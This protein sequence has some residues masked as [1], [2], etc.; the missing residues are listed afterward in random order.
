MGE[1]CDPDVVYFELQVLPILQSNCAMSG[2]HD[3][4]TAQDGVILTSYQRVMQTADVRPYNL[5]GSDLYEVITDNDPDDRMPPPPN[6]RLSQE[7]ISLIGQWIM[8]GAENKTCDPNAGE[9][10]TQNV[11]FSAEI[12][13]VIQNSCTGCHSGGNPS[14]GISLTNHATVSAAAN[15]GKLQGVISWQDG[16]PRMPQGGQKLN[17]CFI[18]KVAAWINAGKPN[19]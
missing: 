2:C 13:P 6:S 1:P 7:Q 3:E 4:A 5:S 11:S 18:D 17:Q 14:G 12:W 15:N 8:Q 9:C 19:N 16:F 10:D